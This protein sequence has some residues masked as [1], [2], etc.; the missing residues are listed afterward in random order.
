MTDTTEEIPN[1]ATGLENGMPRMTPKLEMDMSPGG[2][3]V[4]LVAG[5]AVATAAIIT[6]LLLLVLCVLATVVIYFGR[7]KQFIA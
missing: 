3:S 2:P 4:P 7:K 5:L 6:T 1:V